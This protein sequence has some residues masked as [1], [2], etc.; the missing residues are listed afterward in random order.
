MHIK[1]ALEKAKITMM[2]DNNVFF[3]TNILFSL[4][5]KFTDEIPTAAVNI[6]ELLINP[7][8]FMKLTPEERVGLLLHE[9][10]HIACSHMTRRGNREHQI[11]NM[12]GD[13]VINQLLIDS[14]Y[15]LPKSRLYDSKFKNM[16]TEQVYDVLMKDPNL[17]PDPDMMD[18]QYSD[19]G[20]QEDDKNS[21]GK[22][23]LKDD[24]IKIDNILIR[25]KKQ[26]DMANKEV[27][28]IPGEVL[29]ELEK[30]INPELPWNIIL[31]N[32]LTEFSKNDYSYKRCNRRYLPDFYLP[33]LYSENINNIVIAVD[34][35]GSV[36]NKEF[37]HFIYE[38]DSIKSIFNPE[39]L[40]VIGFDTKIQFEKDLFETDNVLTDIKFSGRGGTDVKDVLDRIAEINP[41]FAIIFT[42]GEFHEPRKVDKYLPVIWVIHNNKQFKSKIGKTIHYNLEYKK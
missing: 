14:G 35:S 37:S 6:E 15:K 19:G 31:Q 23:K 20:D 40:T 7:D 4:V 26:L 32:Y 21:G 33:T 12:A 42:D 3:Y 29:I 13:Y 11:Y 28:N 39:K 38:I 1:K 22:D 18:V 8:F 25:A 5:Q 36:T 16:S 27:G 9:V 41:L 2:L 24:Q 17:Q 10:G 30:R 34:S